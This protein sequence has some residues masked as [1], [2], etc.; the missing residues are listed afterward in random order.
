[1]AQFGRPI[2]NVTFVNWTGG[3]GNIDEITA[4]DADFNYTI[5]KPVATDIAE[6]ALTASL[7]DPVAGVG[8]W[9]MRVR[10]AEIDGGVLGDGSG[11][12]LAD[13]G[14]YQGATLIQ[15]L[16]SVSFTSAWTT[17]TM[18]FTASK[19]SVTDFT[20]LRIRVTWVS[21]GGGSPASRRGLGVSW[22]EIEIPSYAAPTAKPMW[23]NVGGVWKEVLDGWINIGGV[24]KEI[25]G[26]QQN[27]GGEWKTIY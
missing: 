5:D 22:A 6:H 27:I 21:G 3:F 1:M 12:M 4:S 24:W 25:A 23:V 9:L 11:S 7:V 13:V 26:M 14:L 8:N 19:A 17:N 2:S 20:D 10:V 15:A 16:S 18:D